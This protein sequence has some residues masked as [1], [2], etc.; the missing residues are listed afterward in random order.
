MRVSPVNWIVSKYPIEK[1]DA[2]VELDE[3]ELS[4]LSVLLDRPDD[5]G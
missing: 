4:A 3:A 2:V 1:G 5:A